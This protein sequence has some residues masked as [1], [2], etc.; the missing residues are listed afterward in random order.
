MVEFPDF[1]RNGWELVDNALSIDRCEALIVPDVERYTHPHRTD[2]I[3]MEA[4]HWLAPLARKW[5]GPSVSLLGS[6]YF[7]QSAGYATHRDNDFVQAVPGTFLTVW[8]ALADVTAANGPLVVDG[9][10]L[11]PVKAGQ[12]IVLD[13]DLPHRSCAGHGPRPT[14][15]F[16][17]LK[18]GSPFRPGREERVEVPL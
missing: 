5:L 14:A 2:S 3:F 16:T 10:M 4:G 12:A 7:S 13:G 17:Y 9:K 8:L 15:L 18:T 6:Y 11:I 1:R